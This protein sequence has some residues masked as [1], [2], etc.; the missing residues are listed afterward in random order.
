MK[1]ATRLLR[2]PSWAT[3]AGVLAT[4]FL[5][6]GLAS[7]ADARRHADPPFAERP[8]SAI[9]RPAAVDNR[10]VAASVVA[11]LAALLLAPLVAFG[12]GTK[13]RR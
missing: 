4:C 7:P 5:L 13:A 12:A 6:G 3:R 2:R 10:S 1:V 11:T 9:A 8:N